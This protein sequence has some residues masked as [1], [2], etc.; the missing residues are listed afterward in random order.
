MKKFLIAALLIIT[1]FPAFS[2]ED[3][4]PFNHYVGL[5]ANQLIRQLLNFGG[6]ATV[7]NPY[8]FVYSFNSAKTGWGGN[9]G[10]GYT[11]NQIKDQSDGFSSR[12]TTINTIAFRVGF[13]RKIS[14][15]KR[16]LL[17]TGVDI[18]RDSDKDKTEIVFNQGSSNS[19]TTTT[20]IRTTG[21]GS[22]ASLLYNI[23]DKIL[24]A[25]EAT[26]YF[27]AGINKTTLGNIGGPGQNTNGKVKNLQFS[28]PS[29]IF[30]IIKL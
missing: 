16:W 27:K 5:Q 8:S 15:G 13:E 1:A 2:Q 17:G 11:Y 29:V 28:L 19:S 6:S 7:S 23:T 9:V 4:K 3:P 25:T 10:F 18:T 30:L 22:R 14:I 12:T 20:H 26:Y 21:I 24:I